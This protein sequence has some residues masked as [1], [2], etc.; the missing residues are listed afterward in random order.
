MT[1]KA[2]QKILEAP[3]KIM[4]ALFGAYHIIYYL[5]SVLIATSNIWLYLNLK[6]MLVS[7]QRRFMLSRRLTPT[8]LRNRTK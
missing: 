6:T 8:I 5:C 2:P 4:A 3:Q 7:A 1:E